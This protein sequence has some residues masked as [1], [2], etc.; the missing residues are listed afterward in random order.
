MVLPSAFHSNQSAAGIRELFLQKMRLKAC[1]SFENVKK[2]FE[3]HA[4]FKFALVAAVK[5]D[6][7]T[8][9]FSCAFYLHDLEWL[10][11]SRN[12]LTYKR[13]FVEKTGGGYLSLL[14]LRSPA[15]AEVAQSAFSRAEQHGR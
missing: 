1:F 2:L 5:D 4:S 15:D 14:E 11:G 6:T 13:Q 9:E 8:D 3:I 12:S 10:F 7:G